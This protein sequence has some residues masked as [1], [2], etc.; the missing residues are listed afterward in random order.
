MVNSEGE[1]E[2]EDAAMRAGSAV[3][4]MGYAHVP[5]VAAPAATTMN[6]T[7]TP[8][9]SGWIGL[10]I[11]LRVSFPIVAPLIY[12]AAHVIQAKFVGFLGLDRVG[13]VATI[14]IVPRYFVG[15]V[16]AAILIYIVFAILTSSCCILPLGFGRKSELL[17]SQSVQL[18][19][20]LLT[21]VPTYSLHR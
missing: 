13:L 3:V 12:V 8:R 17:S 15:I 5:T 20:K 1:T 7:L 6:A 9:R 2:T 16:A 19:D 14:I 11:A 4:A 18:L 21:I 10:R